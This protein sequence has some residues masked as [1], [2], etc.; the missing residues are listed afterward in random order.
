MLLLVPIVL[1]FFILRLFNLNLIPIFADEAIYIRWAQLILKGDYFI[2]LS[3]GKTPL[4]MW[5]LTPLLK[6][7]SNPLIAGRTLSTISGLATLF[8]VYFLTKKLFNKKTAL[9]ASALVTIQPFLLFYDRLSLVDTLLTALI[10][11]SL[12]LS[13]KLIEKPT[14][15]RALVLGLVWA[16]AL[17]T[18]PSASMFII[19]TPSLL[20]LTP[21]KKWIKKIKTLILPGAITGIIALSIYSLLRIS[22]AF[23]LI[24]S[25]SADY[26]RTPAE[27]FSSWF[28][29]FPDTLNVYLSWINSY[30]TWPGLILLIVSLV[31]SLKHKQ[32]RIYILSLLIIIPVIVQASV[33]KIVYPR[34]LLPIIPFIIIILA[35]GINKLKWFGWGLL[36]IIMFFWIRFDYLLLTDPVNAPLPGREKTQ[37]FYEW[38]A[39]YGLKAITNYLNKLPKDQ[40]VLV[41]T[42]G[43]FG[44]LPNGLEIFFDQSKK[45][46]IT[47]I[48]FP[49]PKITEALETSLLEGK[50]VFLVF[51]QDRLGAVDQSRLTLI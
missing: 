13:L 18:K 26:L 25:R 33:G 29:F 2:P 49:N 30:L 41:A 38:S 16:A 24:N 5:L 43:S 47:G 46:R 15:K 40:D 1:I 42:E 50:S 39:G 10:I 28:E 8:G 11:W 14:L 36:F 17:L 31:L 7:I 34:Y 20:L 23:H 6:I 22:S 19:L 27:F 3:D 32:K 45:I 12:Y 35:W 48:G 44:T 51:N 4:F 37:Y 9:L 21:P